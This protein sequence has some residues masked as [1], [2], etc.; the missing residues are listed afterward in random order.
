MSFVNKMTKNGVNYDIQDVRLTGLVTS[1]EVLNKFNGLSGEEGD[2][3]VFG[4]NGNV[5]SSDNYLKPSEV[6]DP[7]TGKIIDSKIPAGFV[8]TVNDITPV[9]GNVSLKR[10][11]LAD[12]IYSPDNI[13]SYDNYI[14]RTSGGDESIFSGDSD[15]VYIDGH[16]AA[17][18][19]TD[20]SFVYSISSVS[21]PTLTITSFKGN[22]FK[23]NANIPGSG[24]YQFIYSAGAWKLNN[25]AVNLADFGISTSN[26]TA[27]KHELS[28]SQGTG[29][30][31]AVD[32]GENDAGLPILRAKGLA[33]GN[34]LF[35]Y[36]GNAAWYLNNTLISNGLYA[37]YGIRIKA[38]EGGSS[39]ILPTATYT[40]AHTGS[41]IT[42]VALNISTYRQC[43]NPELYDGWDKT[44]GLLY[45][46]SGTDG[47]Y[48]NSTSGGGYTLVDLA[49]LGV[50]ITG[51]PAANDTIT[52][53][54]A[55]GNASVSLNWEAATADATINVNY[56]EGAR[57]TLYVARP[58]SF[59]SVGLNA[60][61]YS[62][63]T[64]ADK[65]I[66]ENGTIIS[67]VGKS[68][69]VVH[70]VGGTRGSTGVDGYTAAFLVPTTSEAESTN[71]ADSQSKLFSCWY[72]E[73][74]IL[75]GDLDSQV[76]ITWTGSESDDYG[77][78]AHC[79]FGSDNGYLYFV[80]DSTVITNLC[81]H[82]AWSEYMDK[83]Y[84][85]YS[86]S[87]INLATLKGKINNEGELVNL[88][89]NT[90]GMPSVGSPVEVAV[91]DELNLDR[92]IYTKKI[93]RLT[94]TSANM[95]IVTA[96]CALHNTD[97]DYD[98]SYIYYV[99]SPS[100]Y[101]VYNV[102]SDAAGTIPASGVYKVHDFGTEE[103]VYESGVYEL[104][105]FAQTLYGQNLKDKLRTD[106]LT[107][108]RMNLSSAQQTIIQDY[109]NV[110][111]ASD[112]NNTLANINYVREDDDTSVSGTIYLDP[113][114]ETALTSNVTGDLTIVLNSAI[115]DHAN[116]WR[117][118]FYNGADDGAASPTPIAITLT[119][120][121][122][123][124]GY[125]FMGDDISATSSGGVVTYTI[126]C[127]PSMFYEISFANLIG[128]NIGVIVKGWETITPTES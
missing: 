15:L 76:T 91:K 61:N 93:A 28:C 22:I 18:G 85:P 121:T 58:S 5:T 13:E 75:S 41:G 30:S 80:V 128:N 72:N 108:S 46:T 117:V 26:L 38:A 71:I 66:D 42:G 10:V 7:Q 32:F 94:N 11:E 81:V 101:V 53:T 95:D 20:D 33:K 52:L 47:W 83:F 79:D 127:D 122:E 104:S 59:K 114:V 37:E 120:I 116:E 124:A 118:I 125:S 50:T 88:P 106:V 49:D 17:V 19:R 44:I 23:N 100:D 67:E 25:V 51:T 43:S 64:L 2:M 86:E 115:A 87:V 24:N 98:N 56:T 62:T 111:S 77:K 29:G 105:L 82:P 48:Y 119:L 103:F 60:Y 92:S 3:L 8:K 65:S 113:N 57:G 31:F 123:D 40:E 1:P 35:R 99:L 84:A 68:I 4:A 63:M 73:E 90:Y 107:V 36:N 102:Y 70:A 110:P 9:N 54:Y 39:A 69:A 34:Y 45:M 16:C 112:V 6:L 21:T 55:T 97:F 14:F 74:K 27:E 78:R 89:L 109:L 96:Y 12:N 126:E